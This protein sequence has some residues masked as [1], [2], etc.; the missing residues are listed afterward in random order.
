MVL[1]KSVKTFAL[2]N[3]FF[4]IEPSGETFIVTAPEGSYSVKEW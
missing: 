4:V 3:G 1:S 2:K